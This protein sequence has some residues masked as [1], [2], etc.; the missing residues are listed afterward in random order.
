MPRRKTWTREQE[1]QLMRLVAESYSIFEIAE[2]MEKSYASVAAKMRRLNISQNDN[3][4]SSAGSQLLSSPLKLPE[5]LPSVEYQLRV[6][7]AT[8]NELKTPGLDKS[9]VMRLRTII[10]GVRAYKEHFA[11]YVG[12]REIEAK[13]DKVIKE[14][15]RLEKESSGMERKKQQ[16][17]AEVT[18]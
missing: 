1:K 13:V 9:E 7:A 12:Y 5:D 14:L 4:R 15:Q 2:K 18:R 6:L 11:D 8:I 3:N 10:N 16:N 17:E